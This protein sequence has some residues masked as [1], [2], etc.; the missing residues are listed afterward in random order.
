MPIAR[1]CNINSLLESARSDRFETSPAQSEFTDLWSSFQF[2]TLVQ[3]WDRSHETLFQLASK[4]AALLG[5]TPKSWL[6]P[7]PCI[8]IHVLCAI[9]KYS[10]YWCNSACR[11]GLQNCLD[12]VAIRAGWW[13]AKSRHPGCIMVEWSIAGPGFAFSVMTMQRCTGVIASFCQTKNFQ[14]SLRRLE[15]GRDSVGLLGSKLQ[16]WSCHWGQQVL[17]PENGRHP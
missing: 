2:C 5:V 14:R 8:R 12:N 17:D 9:V 10:W 16:T 4:T 6:A 7:M 11:T 3:S 13:L 15:Q 1:S